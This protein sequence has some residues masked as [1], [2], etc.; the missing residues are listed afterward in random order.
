VPV[1]SGSG[2]RAVDGWS[3]PAAGPPRLTRDRRCRIVTEEGQRVS[4]ISREREYA[5]R[6]YE[7]WQSKQ[8]DKRARQLRQRRRVIVAGAAVAVV[9]VAA[10]T[11]L[12]TTRDDGDNASTA[13]PPPA[14]LSAPASASAPSS[15]ASA[16]ASAPA[17]ASGTG[18]ASPSAAANPCP[19]PTVK[20]PA[21]P[22]SFPTAPDA[23]LAQGKRWT[24]TLTTS[25]GD[26]VAT[27][28][29]AKAPK[30]VAN[31]IFLSGKKFWDGSPCHRLGATGFGILQC[32]DPTGTGSG[33]PGYQFGP[34]E[35]APADG[36][37]KKG[38]LAM[39]RAQDQNSNGSQFFIVFADTSIPGGYTAF[40]TITKGLDVIEKVA[41]GGVSQPGQDGSGPPTRAISIV[42]TSV[43]PA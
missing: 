14:G 17:S 12:L 32:G 7:K 38:T 20:P 43:T 36:V 8:A 10:G 11:L 27:L 34:V 9:L 41:A 24:L 4:P 1:T 25:C 40:G 23:S 15:G 42:S 31:A 13:L 29:G 16:S 35:N 6:R 26:V 37:F 3:A 22:Q 21:T 33:G 18:A 30:A 39:A 28:D 19:V 2:R 5:R